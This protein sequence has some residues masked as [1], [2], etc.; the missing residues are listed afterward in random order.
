M[1]AYNHIFIAAHR[2][3]YI[4]ILDEYYDCVGP[5]TVYVYT[6]Y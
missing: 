3:N 2:N 6:A 4:I 5:R 1:Q